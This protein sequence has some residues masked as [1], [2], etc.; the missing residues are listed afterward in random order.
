MKI[1]LRRG[2]GIITYNR[3]YQIKEIVEAALD[4]RPKGARVVVADDGSTDDTVSI[5]SAIPEV[6]VLS[7]PTYGV[8]ANK[9]RALFLLQDCDLLALV[10]DDL[11]PV[12]KGWFEAYEDVAIHCDIHHMCRVQDKE[13]EETVP[14]FNQYVKEELGY[15]MIYG[16]SPRGDFTFLTNKVLRTAGGLNPK[17]LGVGHAHGE[18]SDRIARAGLCRH[19][20]KWMDILEARDKFVQV[21]DTKGGRWDRDAEEIKQE[22][23]N[24]AALRNSLKNSSIYVPVHLP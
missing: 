20:L 3:G 4:T 5:V 23:E 8:G 1:S 14:Y 18:Y 15:S 11:K 24:N 10:E 13:L 9:N 7:G 12:E 17:F 19:P 16:K 2:I 22:I 6:T 21:G